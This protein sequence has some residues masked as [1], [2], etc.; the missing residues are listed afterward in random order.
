MLDCACPCVL[1]PRCLFTGI[2]CVPAP[3]VSF[4]RNRIGTLLLGPEIAHF[5]DVTG[6]N[7]ITFLPNSGSAA[8]CV[9][10]HSSTLNRD[11]VLRL[12]SFGNLIP[13]NS[14]LHVSITTISRGEGSFVHRR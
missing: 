5:V 3:P 2:V 10:Q 7:V 4:Y 13:V 12:I 6:T 8:C 1:A 14:C 9:E 11:T